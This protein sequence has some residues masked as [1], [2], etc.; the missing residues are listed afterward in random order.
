MQTQSLLWR[1]FHH[2][3]FPLFTGQECT[4]NPRTRSHASSN[5]APPSHQQTWHQLDVRGIPVYPW[6]CH[7]IEIW[8]STRAGRTVGASGMLPSH[9]PSLHPSARWTAWLTHLKAQAKGFCCWI[10]SSFLSCQLFLRN[11]KRYWLCDTYFKSPLRS[12]SPRSRLR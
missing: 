11:T 5:P 7:E 8:S 2:S 9:P 1:V 10:Y 6:T 4:P 12:L 3:S